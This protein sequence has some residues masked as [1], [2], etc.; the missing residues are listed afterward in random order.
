MAV[1]DAQEFLKLLP[2]VKALPRSSVWLSCEAE[3]AKQFGAAGFVRQVV[4][5]GIGPVAEA[6]Q[7]AS[8][9]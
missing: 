9:Q 4:S 2:T 1:T 6:H 8:A 5:E 3:A 7:Q